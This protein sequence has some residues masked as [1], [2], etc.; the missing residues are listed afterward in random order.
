MQ[1]ALAALEEAEQLSLVQLRLDADAGRQLEAQLE[2][3]R[4]GS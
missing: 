2:A 3:F 4:K 1:G